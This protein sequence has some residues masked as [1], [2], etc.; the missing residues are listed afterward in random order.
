[1]RHIGHLIMVSLK[2]FFDIDHSTCHSAFITVLIVMSIAK[3]FFSRI[4]S[5]F[6][7]VLLAIKGDII[8]LKEQLHFYKERSDERHSF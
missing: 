7:N 6:Y 3:L 8:G 2:Y 4:F 1:M 5:L